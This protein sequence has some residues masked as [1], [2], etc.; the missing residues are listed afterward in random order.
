MV[1][2][3]LAVPVGTNT[4]HSHRSGGK[5]KPCPFSSTGLLFPQAAAGW[6]KFLDGFLKQDS[7]GRP[8]PQ[9]QPLLIHCWRLWGVGTSGGT[10]LHLFFNWEVEKSKPE[11]VM[12]TPPPHTP[13]CIFS[14]RL[15]LPPMHSLITYVWKGSRLGNFSWSS[16][17]LR[18]VFASQG[19]VWLQQQGRTCLYSNSSSLQFFTG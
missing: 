18:V 8:I 3:E 14:R 4:S 6:S 12:Q 7:K 5:V 19:R 10:I 16:S 11:H 2:K 9:L 15:E 17:S 13:P 1:R